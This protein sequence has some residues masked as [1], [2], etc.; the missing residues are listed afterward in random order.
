MELHA[1]VA[2]DFSGMQ[3]GERFGRAGCEGFLLLFVPLGEVTEVA[4]SIDEPVWTIHE[5]VCRAIIA[6]TVSKP[7]VDSVLFCEDETVLLAS[8]MARANI[9]RQVVRVH[10]APSVLGLASTISHVSGGGVLW[11]CQWLSSGKLVQEG[12]DCL[13]LRDW[14]L[15][16]GGE[17]GCLWCNVK[18]FLTEVIDIV[19]HK[20]WFEVKPVDTDLDAQAGICCDSSIFKA[21]VC[22]DSQRQLSGSRVCH[23]IVTANSLKRLQSFC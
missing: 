5:L 7:E 21:N 23:F 11:P 12:L 22:W 13:F 14:Q 8:N 17:S 18:G 20:V 3:L 16:I 1:P 6:S 4:R 19:G 15:W 10:C 2:N 9:W